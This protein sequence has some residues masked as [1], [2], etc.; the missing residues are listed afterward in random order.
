MKRI[1][2]ALALLALAAF[3][4]EARAFC[5]PS[6][7]DNYASVQEHYDAGSE[8]FYLKWTSP[9]SLGGCYPPYLTAQP[10]AGST[11]TAL[12]WSS[13][14]FPG[15]CAS[16]DARSPVPLCHFARPVCVFRAQ[17][18]REPASLFF[19]IDPEECTGLSRPGS[20]WTPI[21]DAPALAAFAV[22]PE[23][24][25]PATTVPLRRFVNDRWSEG[26][27]N[28]RYVAD[29]GVLREMRAK[30][31]WTEE[32]VAFC[33]FGAG[34]TD[35]G[36]GILVLGPFCPS[37]ECVTPTNLAPGFGAKTV[38]PL[39]P[40]DTEAFAVRSG[41]RD[42]ARTTTFVT[43]YSS[44]T[45]ADMAARTF[46]QI[47]ASGAGFQVRSADRAAEGPSLV[48]REKLY[49]ALAPFLATY[50]VDMDFT[51]SYRIFVKRVRAA[52]APGNE[53][54]VQPLVT[55]TDSRSGLSMVLSPGAIGTPEMADGVFRDTASGNV[56]VFVTLGNATSVGTSLGLASLQTSKVFDAENSWG[57]GGDFVYRLKRRDFADILA[58]A[59]ALEPRLSAEPGDYLVESIG[60]KGEVAGDAEVGY[61]VERLE[62]SVTRP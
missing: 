27:G 59:R 45:L 29:E 42:P 14:A 41:A 57:W 30:P 47:F 48:A 16:P 34:R 62:I 1:L 15:N 7:Y 35:V 3:A 21:D 52:A 38:G 55:F 2:G 58:R 19:T 18:Q 32:R 24:Q 51:L 61:N 60:L 39:V 40:A 44:S 4:P 36:R 22:T 17:G 8:R 20:G 37:A 28:H 46:A 56:L 54:Y 26:L 50:E 5:I 53:A 10:P 25:C 31:G 43:G 33:V 6:V 13:W 12:I 49:G 11:F 23:G 9:S